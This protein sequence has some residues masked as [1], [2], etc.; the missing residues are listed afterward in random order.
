MSKLPNNSKAISGMT[1]S[2]GHSLT[3][4]EVTIINSRVRD[5]GI[6]ASIP[7]IK[8]MDDLYNASLPISTSTFDDFIEKLHNKAASNVDDANCCLR[9]IGDT[10]IIKAPTGSAFNN[11]NGAWSEFGFAAYAWNSLAEK[12]GSIKLVQMEVV[13]KLTYT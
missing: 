5:G 2:N 6:K 12:I 7:T 3:E 4:T 1:L 11:C 8:T 9:D 10:N 13:M